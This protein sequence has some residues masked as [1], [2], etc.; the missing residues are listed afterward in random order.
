MLLI[1]LSINIQGV[2]HLTTSD[3]W[4]IALY[5]CLE[6]PTSPVSFKRSHDFNTSS[7]N[8]LLKTSSHSKIFSQTIF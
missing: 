7:S 6:S 8:N 1:N 5:Y 2:G 4:L 3:A